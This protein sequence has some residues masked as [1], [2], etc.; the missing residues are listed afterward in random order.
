M[1]KWLSQNS[2]T[3]AA[4][5]LTE[6]VNVLS[7]LKVEMD[8]LQEEVK[9]LEK[10]VQAKR[11]GV[12]KSLD[13][14]MV[15][16]EEE[17]DEEVDDVIP[18]PS[19]LKKGPRSSVSAEAY[20]ELKA[21]VFVPPVY[22]KSEAPSP[23]GRGTPQDSFLFAALD[24]HELKVLID[25]MQE[26]IV[27]KGTRLINQGDDGDC[28]YV[29]EHGQMNCFIRQPD[30][31][32]RKVKECTAGDA[33]G[34]LALLYNCPRAA[35]VE[36]GERSV[37]W[38]LDR[39]SFNNIVKKAAA[40]HREQLEEFLQKVP[41]LQTM[42]VHERSAVCDALRPVTFC[43]GEVIVHQGE[44]GET[45]YLVED[46][47]ERYSGFP[48]VG[49]DVQMVRKRM[50]RVWSPQEGTAVVSKVYVPGTPAKEVL[51]LAHGDYFGEL[52]LLNNDLRA[53]TVTASSTCRCLAL[54]RRTFDRLLGPLEDIL[55]RNA[56]EYD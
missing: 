14:R 6:G 34:E 50:C 13:K 16:T 47:A 2:K 3:P 31:G 37:L 33:F 23:G 43:E 42:E 22:P 44:I 35:S 19:Y 48:A 54:S 8:K 32:E 21:K 49:S 41:L 36:A 9:D 56:T 1:I 12:F 39:E 18:P 26:K 52:A 53:A 55:R 11:G 7:E 27:E 17:E 15:V 20:G 45:F 24:G 38:M 25:A 28:L 10:Q 30:G 4:A 46:R 29:V 40:A 5:A 51:R